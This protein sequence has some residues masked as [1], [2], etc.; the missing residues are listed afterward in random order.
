MLGYWVIRHGIGL[1]FSSA[2]GELTQGL[3]KNLGSGML[4]PLAWLWLIACCL[5]A[6]ASYFSQ[7]K[8]ERIL[9]TQ[10]NLD[11][12]RALGWRE[13]EQL[14]GEAYRRQGWTVEETGQGGADGGID[15]LLRRDGRTELV[16]CK[17]WRNRQVNVSVVREMFGLLA[18]HGANGVRIISVGE[19]TRDAAAFVEGK[20]IQLINGFRLLQLV[21]SVQNTRPVEVATPAAVTNQISESNAQS[22]P[23]CGADMVERKNKSNGQRFWGCT[24]FPRC[25]GTRPI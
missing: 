3:G 13:F 24:G 19:F 21:Q 7:K 14:V 5:A 11:S 18:H 2:G 9:D 16:Q 25:H 6:L 15:L 10:R 1:Y 12:V 20:P 4:A 8:R 23:T 22:C 17:Q